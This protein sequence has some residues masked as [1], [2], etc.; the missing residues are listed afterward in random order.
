MCYAHP[1]PRCSGHARVAR[2]NAVAKLVEL[3]DAGM[4]GTKLEKARGKVAEKLAIY[5]STPD[6]QEEL[7]AQ[8]QKEENPEKKAVLQKRLNAGVKMRGDALAALREAEAKKDSDSLVDHSVEIGELQKTIDERIKGDEFKNLLAER[9]KYRELRKTIDAETEE[10][11]K[12]YEIDGDY[13]PIREA[14]FRYAIAHDEFIIANYELGEY[15]DETAQLVAKLNELQGD[16]GTEYDSERLGNCVR[17]VAYASGTKEWLEQR[18]GGIGGSDVGSI[19]KVDKEFAASNYN[20]VF[21]SKVSAYTEEEIAEQASNNSEFTG[22][23]GRGNAWEPAIIRRFAEENPEMTVLY[24]KASWRNKDDLTAYANVDGLLASDGVNPDGILE[25][26]TA[27]DAKKWDCGVPVGYRAQVLWYLKNTGFKYAHVAVMIDDHEYRSYRIDADETIDGTPEG[28]TLEEEMPRIRK[29]WKDVET[30][31]KTGVKPASTR[32]AKSL[33]KITKANRESMMSH[34]AA[35]RQEDVTV[36]AAR[37]DNLVASGVDHHDAMMSLYNSVEPKD[38]KKDIVSVDLETSA[39]TERT[40][41][42]I[43]IGITRRN[44]KNEVVAEY[45]RRFGLRDERILD[46]NGTGFEDVHKI[47][48]EDIRGERPFSDPQ[49]QKEV[50]NLMKGGVML[51]HN[52]TYELK[53]LKQH[54]E[55]FHDAKLPVIDTMHIS[56]YQ[57]PD[58]PNNK[59]ASFSEHHGIPYVDAHSALPDAQMTVDA[60]FNFMGSRNK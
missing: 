18:Q 22:A 31:R 11:K 60:L 3:V 26:K 1:G 54:L 36:S 19:L 35:F 47:T 2:E 57:V 48:P 50:M 53:W 20:E 5:D 9:D 34:L 40:G 55:G 8:I 10:L 24:T 7:E 52:K 29:F 6:G 27:S 59:L 33:Y 17:T 32:A 25:I 28:K 14:N 43:E 37:F 46:I 21:D 39:S 49:V 30:T 12:Q 58:S 16:P 13:E 56:R 4:S 45:G 44:S 23:T 15:K 42:I 38:W 51:A 41:S